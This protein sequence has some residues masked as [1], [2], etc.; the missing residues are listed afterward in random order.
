[1]FSVGGDNIKIIKEK[2]EAAV[3]VSQNNVR[4]PGTNERVISIRGNFDSIKTCVD[5]IQEKIR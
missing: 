1:M 2:S 4:F 3:V 5:M